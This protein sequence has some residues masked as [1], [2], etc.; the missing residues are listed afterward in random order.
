MDIG[1]R[2]RASVTE[3]RDRYIRTKNQP[4]W[5]ASFSSDA[6]YM[7]VSLAKLSNEAPG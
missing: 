3:R 6:A 5:G 1:Q 4:C 7:L 2:M